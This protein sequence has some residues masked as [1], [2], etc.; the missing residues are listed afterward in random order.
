[1]QH[2]KGKKRGHKLASFRECMNPDNNTYFDTVCAVCCSVTVH[3]EPD[4]QHLDILAKG[5]KICF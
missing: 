4:P 2:R 5:L 1:M 3:S